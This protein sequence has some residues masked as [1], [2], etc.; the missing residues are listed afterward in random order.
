MSNKITAQR[1]INLIVL[2]T[3]IFLNTEIYAQSINNTLPADTVKSKIAAFLNFNDSLFFFNYRSLPNTALNAGRITRLSFHGDNPEQY[4]F[5]SSVQKYFDEFTAPENQGLENAYYFLKNDL[6][7]ISDNKLYTTVYDYVASLPEKDILFSIWRKNIIKVEKETDMIENV[8]TSTKEMMALG[9]DDLGKDL[10]PFITMLMWEQKMHHYDKAR[11]ISTRKGSKGIVT[12]IQIL[13]ALES[14]DNDFNA[15]VCRD[16]HDWGLRMLRPMLTEYYK[17]KN[18]A[19]VYNVDDYVFLQAWVTPSSQHVTIAVVDPDSSRNYYELDWGSVLKKENQEGVEI[20]K[21]TGAAVRLWQYQPEKNVTQAFNLLRTQ[22]GTYFD[23][24]FF[25]NDE[26]WLFNGIYTPY[27]ASS[28]D[29]IV[30]AG[31]KSEINISL[32]MLNASEKT[33]SINYRS[34]THEFSFAKI[35]QYS[36][37][38]GIQ[39]MIIDDTQRKNAA[40]AWDEWYSS[41]NLANSVR[42]IMN[43]KTKDLE[44]L[45]NLKA[46]IYALSQIEFFLSLSHFKSNDIEFNDKLQGSGDGN[47]WITWGV[48]LN[49]AIKNFELDTKFGSRNFLIPKDVRLLSPN[50]F[51]LMSNAVIANSGN[52]LLLHGKFDNKNWLIEPEFRFEQNKMNA[53]FVLYSLKL[54]KSINPQNRFFMESGYY[55]Q[56]KGIEYYWYAKSRYWFS[57]GINSYKKAFDLSLYSELIKGDFIT[58]GLQFNKYLNQN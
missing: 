48:H 26:D 33:L 21:M 19:K 16:V 50:P 45:P 35:F 13:N 37:L 55:N 20:G 40:M 41:L 44:I 6:Q 52:G 53:Q 32:G 12:S 4:K 7:S 28:T 54:G 29:Y 27:Y 49:Y 58:I 43:V 2:I 34:G 3:L 11:V 1:K 42:Y 15:G 5:N 10:F 14:L 17:E 38:L 18:P 31:K 25:K 57:L 30:S 36:G 46:N 23:R 24:H 39:S 8:R 9:Y 56:I 51:V 47:I 22:W